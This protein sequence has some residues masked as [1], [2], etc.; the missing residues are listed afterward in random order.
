MRNKN[1]VDNVNNVKTWNNKYQLWEG[2]V[3]LNDVKIR[4]F[5]IWY[6]CG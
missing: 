2:Q 4:Y 6:G 5:C 1:N 3:L